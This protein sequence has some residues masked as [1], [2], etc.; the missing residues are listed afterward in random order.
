MTFP[1]QFQEERLAG[2]ALTL[3]PMEKCIRETI[4]YTRQR[5]AFGRSIL[6]NQVVHFRLAELSTEVEAL[7]ALL[8]ETIGTSGSCRTFAVRI[9]WGMEVESS[10]HRTGARR[11]RKK[12]S[13]TMS[14]RIL[15]HSSLRS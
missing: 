10:G 7:R 6:D 8:Y 13:D 14:P 2:V 9:W 4:E 11:N 15:Q 3:R 5:R 1:L 12:F